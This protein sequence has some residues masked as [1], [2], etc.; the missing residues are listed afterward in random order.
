ML[1]A[2][3]WLLWSTAAALSSVRLHVIMHMYVNRDCYYVYIYVEKIHADK[4]VHICMHVH[5][6]MYLHVFVCKSGFSEIHAYTFTYM[7]S[8]TCRYMDV[9]ALSRHQADHCLIISSRL[10][11]MP[12]GCSSCTD[13]RIHHS[14]DLIKI[15]GPVSSLHNKKGVQ[16]DFLFK[17]SNGKFK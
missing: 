6:C 9:V 8:D 16:G 13:G 1:L 5:L 15:L 4:H 2:L 7:Q 10:Q 17:N 11:A 14:N 3:N 12:V